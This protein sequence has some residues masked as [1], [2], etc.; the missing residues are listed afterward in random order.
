[1]ITKAAQDDKA[2]TKDLIFTKSARDAWRLIIN[3]VKSRQ[4]QAG[5]LLPSYI[6]FTEREGSGIFDP[7]E[8]TDATFDFY[9]LGNDLSVDIDSF[10]K[11]ISTKRF[12]IALVVHYF[13]FCRSDLSRIRESCDANN[14]VLV[15]D[16]AHAFQL[17]LQAEGLGV[18]GDFSI[19]SIHKWLPV[20]SGGILKKDLIPLSFLAYRTK[21]KFL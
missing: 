15:E 21:I 20:D 6:G 10:E 11:L 7:V 14:V 18:L 5:I 8:N 16:C 9:G 12:N 3:S 17:G 19:Y 4:G 2:F 1:M 13:G